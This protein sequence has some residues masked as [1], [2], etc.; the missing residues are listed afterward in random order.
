MRKRLR[1][2][3]ALTLLVEAL[4]ASTA[5]ADSWL[6][7]SVQTINSADGRA[8]L[9]IT[10]RAIESPL[11]Y[12]Q[13]R[14]QGRE[15]AGQR[16]GAGAR[17]PVGRLQVRENGRWRTV[18]ERP[19]LNDVAP[20]RALVA[21]GGRRV[22]TFDNWHS[23]GHGDHVIV[24]YDEAGQPIRSLRLDEVLPDYYIEALPHTVSSLWWGGE[25]RL[26]EGAD[27]LILS[28]A[29]PSPD[30]NPRS[31]PFL[32]LPVSLVTG[33]PDSMTGARWE[34]ARA[35][36]CRNV[37]NER[38]ALLRR[39]AYLAAPLLGPMT[40]DLP[41]WHEYLREAVARLEVPPPPESDP[42]SPLADLLGDTVSTSTTVLH[43]PASPE[44]RQSVPHVVAALTEDPWPG[45]VRS[46]A[47]PAQANLAD[48]LV[49]VA[50]RVPRDSLRG[51]RVYIAV[52]DT[53]WPRVIQALEASGAELRQ[54]DPTEPIPQRSGRAA[55][56]V[57]AA[58]IPDLPSECAVP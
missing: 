8:R 26:D 22:V 27:R 23:M 50:R 9:T 6:P 13:D 1:L 16:A 24:I 51:V 45:D 3:A 32:D 52:G 10:P 44:Y 33:M 29:V 25:H 37:R 42:D 19:L 14:V 31:G 2:I 41:A 30:Q 56:A 28:I 53:H 21:N 11:S 18:W 15:P 35:A 49:D 5:R 7:P 57:A 20:V 40:S 46:I 4:L 48:V 38:E 47:S 12:F 54:L 36:A 39:R 43:D 55:V 17:H 34:A 58:S